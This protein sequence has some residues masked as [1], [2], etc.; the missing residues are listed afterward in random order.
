VVE[1]SS[2]I[3]S[4]RDSS[5]YRKSTKRTKFKNKQQSISI[6]NNPLSKISEENT[7]DNYNSESLKLENKVNGCHVTFV[8]DDEKVTSD[9]SDNDK[10]HICHEKENNQSTPG[11][12]FFESN[13]NEGGKNMLWEI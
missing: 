6:R 7:D 9:T 13:K 1:N 2:E 4:A 12:V 5:S 11:N 3:A 10:E 8:C